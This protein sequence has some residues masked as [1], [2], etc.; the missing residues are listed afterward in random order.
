MI[1]RPWSRM[2]LYAILACVSSA[3]APTLAAAQE[4]NLYTTREPGLIQ[5]LIDG[6]GKAT[7]ITV[8][9]IFVKDGLAE[10]VAAEGAQSPADVLMTVDIGNLIDLTEKGLSQPVQSSALEQAIP[11]NLRGQS[12]EWFALSMRARV[13]YA[14]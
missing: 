1:F 8:K 11:V 4:L 2:C 13:V 3:L 7:G 5:P 6:F 9:T 14:A 12:G 10:R